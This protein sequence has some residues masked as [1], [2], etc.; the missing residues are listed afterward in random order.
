MNFCEFEASLVY[1]AS[2]RTGFKA[3]Q[4]NSVSKIKV[5]N[6]EKDLINYSTTLLMPLFDHFD[7]IS[8]Y[9]VM[10]HVVYTHMCVCMIYITVPNVYIFIINQSINTHFLHPVVD[11][12]LKSN[13]PD[14]ALLYVYKLQ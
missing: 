14:F 4:R 5:I 1:R 12:K 9:M 11:F 7:V 2:V 6:K 8:I 10:V 3:T 13:N